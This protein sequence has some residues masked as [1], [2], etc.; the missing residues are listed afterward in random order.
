MLHCDW[1]LQTVAVAVA[2]CVYRAGK[3][4]TYSKF[5]VDLYLSLSFTTKFSDEFIVMLN[6]PP[7]FECVAT[8]LCTLSLIAIAYIF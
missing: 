6:N 1:R 2:M 3:M 7:N 4:T 8:L 5:S